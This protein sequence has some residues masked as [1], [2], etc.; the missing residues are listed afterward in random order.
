[1]NWMVFPPAVMDRVFPLSMPM[2][3]TPSSKPAPAANTKPKRVTRVRPVPAVTRA[4]AI[5]RLLGSTKH[6]LGVKAIADELEL[7][8]S[9]CL[10]ILRVLVSED[11]VKPEP[12]T[13][14]YALGSGMIRLARSVLEGGS[15]AH[16]S[17]PALDRLASTHGVT[18]MGVELGSNQTAVVVSISQSKQPFR[19]HTDVGSQFNTLVSATGRLI[20][21]HS[22]EGWVELRKKFN[23][24]QWDCAPKFADWRKEV[25][26]ARERGWSVDRDNFMNGITVVAVPVLS[27]SGTLTHTLVAVGL[28]AH[29][30]DKATTEIARVM[31]QEATEIKELLLD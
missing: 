25:E 31:R 29:L 28:T 13:K 5:L 26:Q 30:N 27:R 24:I 21:A 17:Q 15:F 19:V 3:Q 20:A 9:T 12:G 14:R 1:M 10:H 8:P 2:S 7:V 16:L 22:G 23:A 11:L 4:I 18:A 6:P